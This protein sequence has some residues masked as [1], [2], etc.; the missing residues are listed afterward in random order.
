MKKRLPAIGSSILLCLLFVSA[1]AQVDQE[2]LFNLIVQTSTEKSELTCVK[3]NGLAVTAEQQQQCS[4]GGSVN[5]GSGIGVAIRFN[6]A[7]KPVTRVTITRAG[8][9]FVY[10]GGT[11][12]HSEISGACFTASYTAT[13]EFTDGTTCTVSSTG[14]PPHSACTDT[15]IRNSAAPVHAAKFNE[16]MAPGTISA[17]FSEGLT[18]QTAQAVSIPLPERLADV[19]AYVFLNT[20]RQQKVKLFYVD[21]KQVNLLLPDD[22]PTGGL[23]TLQLVNTTGDFLRPGYFISNKFEPGIFTESG[24][25]Q[26]VAAGYRESGHAV[27]FG[28]GFNN[29]SNGRLLVGNQFYPAS[30][31]GRAPG[32]VGLWQANIPTS[33]PRGTTAQLCIEDKCSQLFQLP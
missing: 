21:P 16:L 22:I 5:S 14:S 32:F 10:P 31:V 27:L 4:F 33:F 28:S 23:A 15:A 9:S 12:T 20:P 29:G 2:K 6:Y 19:E 26:G 25:G 13:V 18:N 11:Q 3:V 1:S 7:N 17:T 8:I 24:N 30:F